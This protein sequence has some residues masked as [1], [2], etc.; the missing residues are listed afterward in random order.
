VAA[1]SGIGPEVARRLVAALDR[2][3]VVSPHGLADRVVWLEAPPE[4]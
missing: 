3:A 1:T 4:G 2:L